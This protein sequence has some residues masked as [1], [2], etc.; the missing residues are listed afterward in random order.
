MDIN[1]V[2]QQF[3]DG[4]TLEA[5]HL[6]HIEEGIKILEQAINNLKQDI[7]TDILNS[8]PSWDGGAY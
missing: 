7:I 3:S 4:Q 1:Y 8:L 6:N 2:P 5:R